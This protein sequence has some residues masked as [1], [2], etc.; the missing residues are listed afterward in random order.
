MASQATAI[1]QQQE[2]PSHLINGS[3]NQTARPSPSIVVLEDRVSSFEMSPTSD[4]CCHTAEATLPVFQVLPHSRHRSI[5]KRQRQRVV[6]G[7]QKG[8]G[9]SHVYVPECWIAA[10]DP[11]S[12][13]FRV[14]GR[15]LQLPV[16]LTAEH[17]ALHPRHSGGL[18]F[19]GKPRE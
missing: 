10:R 3:S 13:S 9:P 15:I 12:L 7:W 8:P 18:G 16:L 19:G 1:G 6:A 2:A 5:S 14:L 11:R 17:S 4:V